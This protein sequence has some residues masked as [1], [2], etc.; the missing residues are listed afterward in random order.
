MHI[1][2]KIT[3]SEEYFNQTDREID[4]DGDDNTKVSE[5]QA[6]ELQRI[7]AMECSIYLMRRTTGLCGSLLSNMGMLKIELINKYEQTHE[8]YIAP[9]D[10]N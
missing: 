4:W 2:L 3:T 10:F 9:S 6:N 5:E 1:D 7:L 8:K